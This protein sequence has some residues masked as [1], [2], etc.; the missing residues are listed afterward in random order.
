MRAVNLIPQ[1][2]RS[3]GGAG[4]AGR[5]GGVAYILL[6][7]LGVVVLLVLATS[8]SKRSVAD[9][10]EQVTQLQAQAARSETDETALAAYTQFAELRTA[11]VQLVRALATD[12]F[13]WAHSLSEVARV[14]PNDVWLTSLQATVEP[15]VSLK[16]GGSGSTSSLRSAIAQPAVEIVGCTTS[17]KSVTRML[18]RMRLVDGVTRVTLASSAKDAPEKKGGAASAAPAGGSGSS[19]EGCRLGHASFPEFSMVMFIDPVVGGVP[20]AARFAE[21]TSGF[22]K[23]GW[24]A[25]AAAKK[26]R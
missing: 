20:T 6:G 13:D 23:L 9:K 19:A 12:R 3:G 15:G 18:G 10:R 11:R 14:I 5:S 8:L 1:T 24:L 22:T 25:A 26:S 2:E 7:A 17:L 21:V 4:S 16:A